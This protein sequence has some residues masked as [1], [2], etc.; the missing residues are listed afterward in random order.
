MKQ[1]PAKNTLNNDR[2]IATVYIAPT[3]L[4]ILCISILPVIYAFRTSLHET[5]YGTVGEFI[6]FENYRQIF[7]SSEGWQTIFNSISYAFMSLL[8]VIPLGTFSA[9]LLN[10]KRPLVTLF[11]TLIILPWVLSQTVTALLWKWL[12]NGN[13]GPV[14]YFWFALTGRKAD[15][16]NT[17]LTARLAIVVVNAWFTFPIV[18]IMVLAALQSI[19]VET[20]EAAEVDGASRRQTLWMITLPMIRPTILTSIVMQSMEYFSMVTLIFVMTAGGPF[21]ATST[22][23]LKAFQEGFTFWHMGLGSAYSIVI[24]LLN[25]VFTL[26][27]IRILRSSDQ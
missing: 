10:R 11:R 8:I 17:E 22:I 19:P 4:L 23:S 7:G 20:F 25:I 15:F 18:L 1:P 12:L 27:Y 14:S 5:V 21:G 13:F 2:L 3:I 9:I 16:F 6:G 24:F 26:V